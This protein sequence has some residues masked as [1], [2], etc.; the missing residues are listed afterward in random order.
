MK[1]IYQ[2]FFTLFTAGILML[3]CSNSEINLTQEQIRQ[4]N[5]QAAFSDS[6]QPKQSWRFDFENF[7]TKKLPPGWT[8]Y[9]SGSGGTDW[10]VIVDNGNK[11]LAQL[12][13]K[14]PGSHFNIVVND[15][16]TAKDVIL[17]T[18]LKGVN[19]K[20]DQGGGF[21][22][23][24]LNK[25]NYYVV[26]ANPLENNVVLYKVENGDRTDLPLVDKGK[27]YGIEVDAMKNDWHTLKLIVKGNVFT[28]F[29]NDKELFKVQDN[30]FAS[31]GKIGFWTKADAVSYFD[32]L[33]VNMYE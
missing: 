8:Q 6:A 24:F 29:M 27:T 26:R 10:Q 33:E 13:S 32:D 18:R 15:S 12:Y 16:I 3:A 23:R 4:I 11:V 28:V 2:S 19:G 5:E 22:W 25:E 9:F 17:T 20:K 30:T 21:V 31:A 7:A 1:L 14:N